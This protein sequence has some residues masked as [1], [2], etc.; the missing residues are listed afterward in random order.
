MVAVLY[1]ND[2]VMCHHLDQTLKQF[3]LYFGTVLQVVCTKGTSN[4]LKVEH[5]LLPRFVPNNGI[6]SRVIIELLEQLNAMDK[7]LG[8]AQV[9]KIFAEKAQS[10]MKAS[11][12]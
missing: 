1:A 10:P 6:H 12:L 11:D 9:Q 5:R 4:R 2:C 7:F 3:T 8:L